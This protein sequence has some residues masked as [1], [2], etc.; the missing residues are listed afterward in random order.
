MKDS[1]RW[2]V[3]EAL[4]SAVADVEPV[5]GGCICTGYR[6]A[7]EDGHRVFV[8]THGSPPPAFFSVEAAGLRWLA[9]AGARV[10]SVL[11]VHDGT[12]SVPA[13]LVLELIEPGASAPDTD[14]RLGR[15]LARLHRAG[16]PAFGWDRSGYIGSLPQTNERRD[17]WADFYLAC[18]LTPM[19]DRAIGA[20]ELPESA[21]ADLERL[22]A[23]LSDLVGEP[24]AP[25]RVHGDLW[26][27][28]LLVGIGGVP[29]LID[30]APYGGHREMDLAMMQ[31]FGGY[32]PRCFAAYDE[33]FPRA[34]GH[35]DRVGLYQLYPL[36]VHVVLFGAGYASR[37]LDVLRRYG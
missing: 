30:P 12:D 36:L 25:S 21:R 13:H 7:L 8:K 20:G 9:E 2:A 29:W 27:G 19:L 11:D 5:G 26:S 10:P 6:V 1:L 34:P 16:A 17:T 31:L 18:R 23:R 33:V 4:G 32:G 22:G 37:T 24:E 35:A 28:N 15:D 14:E 3:G